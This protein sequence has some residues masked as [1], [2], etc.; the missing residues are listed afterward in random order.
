MK[1][2]IFSCVIFISGIIMAAP[3]KIDT[4][5][6]LKVSIFFSSLCPGSR[7]FITQQLYPNYEGLKHR[8][9]IEWVLYQEDTGFDDVKFYCMHGSKECDFNRYIVCALN[10]GRG[11]DRDVKFINCI[12]HEYD[13]RNSQWI[14]SRD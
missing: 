5:G 6:L 13:F 14:T 12:M 7:K 2:G 8:I 1:T 3:E 9:V 11:Q 4:N 10:Q